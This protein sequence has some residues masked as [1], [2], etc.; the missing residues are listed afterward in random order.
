[1]EWNGMARIE[2]SFL[3]IPV[4]HLDK[5]IAAFGKVGKELG[6]ILKFRFF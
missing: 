6:V 4:K 2:F 5:A 1:M 3:D